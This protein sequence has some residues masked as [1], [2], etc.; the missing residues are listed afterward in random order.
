MP[1]RLHR[2][3]IDNEDLADVDHDPAPSPTKQ[4]STLGRDSGQLNRS[5]DL[6]Q[7][8]VFKSK[9]KLQTTEDRQSNEKIIPKLHLVS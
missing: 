9:S 3:K 1:Y 2:F 4:G 5:Y 7:Q 8:S 6:Q